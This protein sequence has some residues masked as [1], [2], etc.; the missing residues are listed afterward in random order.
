MH[1]S[2][3]DSIGSRNQVVIGH[4]NIRRRCDTIAESPNQPLMLRVAAA[5]GPALTGGRASA[6][7]LF[8][9]VALAREPREFGPRHLTEPLRGG[10]HSGVG[11]EIDDRQTDG[12]SGAQ[13]RCHHPV[14]HRK[15][16]RAAR[17][18]PV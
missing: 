10:K 1:F 4:D 11:T 8:A 7:V 9:R 14:E 3:I 5:V 2:C 12:E 17:R 18:I 16:Y 13:S 15:L 6:R